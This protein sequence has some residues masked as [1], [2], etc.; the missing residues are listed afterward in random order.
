MTR[1]EL[2]SYR[3]S[4]RVKVVCWTPVWTFIAFTIEGSEW[5][6]GVI[7]EYVGSEVR[8]GPR[9]TWE[10]L[11][12]SATQPCSDL[13]PMTMWDDF[14][15]CK[16]HLEFHQRFLWS[17]KQ[18]SNDAK[19]FWRVKCPSVIMYNSVLFSSLFFFE[20]LISIS[21]L[22]EHSSDGRKGKNV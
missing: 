6:C 11:A 5:R 15:L 13:P 4:F 21:S 17:S 2:L 10:S 8:K 16:W 14:S 9:N 18:S 20:S 22:G 1:I 7:K 19:N 3:L 12:P